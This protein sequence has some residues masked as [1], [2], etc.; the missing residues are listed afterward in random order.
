MSIEAENLLPEATLK[1][2]TLQNMAREVDLEKLAPK[3]EEIGKKSEVEKVAVV[4]QFAAAVNPNASMQQNYLN[5]ISFLHAQDAGLAQATQIFARMSELKALSETVDEDS[6][7]MAKYEAEFQGLLKDVSQLRDANYNGLS[8]FGEPAQEERSEP[9]IQEDRLAVSSQHSDKEEEEADKT[10]SATIVITEASEGD[11]ISASVNGMT[12]DAVSAKK[13]ANETAKDLAESINTSAS[14][15]IATA[16][17][18][19]VKVES[20]ARFTLEAKATD[21]ESGA[22]T[23]SVSVQGPDAVQP[24]SKSKEN[25]EKEK[26]DPKPEQESQPFRLVGTSEASQNASFRPS[27]FSTIVHW[28]E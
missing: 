28:S 3:E 14:G 18:G 7:E 22:T 13:N 23:G 9:P 20:E 19:V 4:T 11:K 5:A 1:A 2:L 6:E 24:A 17:A 21:A 8:I 10:Y 15:V 25:T 12:V 16:A 27:G 26:E